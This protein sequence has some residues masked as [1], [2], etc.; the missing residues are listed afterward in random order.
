[1]SA[2][3]LLDVNVMVALIWPSHEAHGHVQIW[4]RLNSTAGWATCPITQAGF[5][6]I[7]SNPAFSRDAVPPQ[8]A[9]TLL[10]NNLK[11]PHHH[12]WADDVGFSKAAQ[13]F[14]EQL[15]G[16]KQVTDAYLLGLASHKKARLVSLDRAILH[17]L[18][19]NRLGREL[20]IVL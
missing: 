3:Y 17:L 2:G 15:T 14:F 12:F 16:H 1:M 6:R 20:V 18:P 8:E 7:V 13:P 5:V 9:I 11:H 4:F 10:E 19:E